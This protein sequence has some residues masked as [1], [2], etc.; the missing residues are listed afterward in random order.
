D[1]R[2]PGEVHLRDQSRR[3]R[4]PHDGKMNVLRAPGVAMI[5]PGIRPRLDRVDA[6]TPF[7]VR[8]HA[9]DAGE[10]RVERGVVLVDGM[11]I[12]ARGFRLPDLDQGFA[13][14]SAAFLENAAGDDDS[15]ADRRARVLLRQIGNRATHDGAPVGRASSLRHRLWDANEWLAGRTTP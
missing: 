14:G 11:K 12:A 2:V 3:E 6:I 7:V 9:A 4:W 1:Q 8:D 13:H 10:V 15:L 5:S